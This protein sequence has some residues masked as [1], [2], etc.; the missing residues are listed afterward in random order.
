MNTERI[1]GKTVLQDSS[2]RIYIEAETLEIGENVRFDQDTNIRV[3]GLLRIGDHSKFGPRFHINAE[4]VEIGKHFFYDPANPWNGLNIGGGSSNFPTA[5]LKVGDRCVCHAGHW[6]LARSITLGDDVGLSYDTTLLTHGFWSSVLEGYPAVFQPIT[7]GNNVILGWGSTLL[8]GTVIDDNVVLGARS[9][10]SGKHITSGIWVGQ[11]ARKIKSITKPAPEQQ[12]EI[13]ESML[14]QI[15]NVLAHYEG[16]LIMCVDYPYLYINGC[17]LDLQEQS[18]VSGTGDDVVLAC[19]D[20]LRRF[21]IRIFTP[22]GFRFNLK[23]RDE[24]ISGL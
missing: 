5:H 23:R 3:R 8:A 16:E 11:P 22:W 21:G 18:W 20:L 9:L 2:S 15:Q 7:V 13:L 24:K 12:K 4:S 10:V 6:N 14:I 1:E 17:C 19:I